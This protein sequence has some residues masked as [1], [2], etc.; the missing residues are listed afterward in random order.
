MN[1]ITGP[2]RAFGIGETKSQNAVIKVYSAAELK[3]ALTKIYQLP[4]GVGTIEIAGDIVITEPIKLRSFDA[5]EAAPREIIIQS[6]SGARILNGNQSASVT[7]NYNIAGYNYIP[8]FDF[9]IVN[10]NITNNCKYTFKDL[11]I[12]SPNAILPF[13]ALIGFG[14]GASTHQTAK[15]AVSNLKAYKLGMIFGAYSPISVFTQSIFAFNYI[16][17]DIAIDNSNCPAAITGL[18]VSSP[19][20]ILQDSN[21]SNYG[22]IDITY[23]TPASTLFFN[24]GINQRCL[25]QNIKSLTLING[26][27]VSLGNTCINCTLTSNNALP[28]V[29]LINCFLTTGGIGSKTQISTA[30]LL[31]PSSKNAFT[32][33][34]QFDTATKASIDQTHNI[35]STSGNLYN[36]DTLLSNAGNYLLQYNITAAYGS[37][38]LNNYIIRASVRYAGG[39]YIITSTSTDYAAEMITTFNT[40]FSVTAGGI[41]LATSDATNGPY[42]ITG[43]I[44]ITGQGI[45]S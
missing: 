6:I 18:Y 1:W 7:Y 27:G 45:I 30:G 39:I 32:L 13:G 21:I 25:L 12:N 16:I 35:W 9:G 44:K 31:G 37:G 41:R 28:Y 24:S 26:T 2:N 34:Y 10:S 36:I 20:L 3:S 33:Y 22:V 8:V 40:V 23:I 17:S 43:S 15:I 42:T 5:L 29:D 19:Q 38:N 14:L 4:S 11:C